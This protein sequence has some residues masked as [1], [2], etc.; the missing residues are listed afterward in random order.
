[1][2]ILIL[3]PSSLGDVIQALPVLRLLKLHYPTSE[4]YWWIETSLSPILKK[5]PDLAGLFVFE[6][7]RWS[8]PLYWNELLGSIRQMRSKKFDLVIDLQGLARSGTFAWLA[9][10]RTLIGVDDSREGASAYYDIRVPRPSSQGH[11]VDW[12]LEVVKRLG[13]PVDRPFTWLPAD[14][15]VKAI[16]DQQRK[17]IGK[18]VVLNPGARWANKRWPTG[19]FAKLAQSL[20]SDFPD[21]N[22]V[23]TGGKSESAL[24]TAISAELPNRC[25]D[26]VGRTT[27]VEMIEWI[28]G[29]ELIVTNDTGP[30]HIAAALGKQVLAVFGPT[31]P[32]RTGPY[33]PG[34]Q[35]LRAELPCAPCMKARCA[36]PNYLECLT[37]VTPE[38]VHTAAH[39][40][41]K[42][43]SR[44]YATAE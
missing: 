14:N 22:F 40:I 43:S 16:V 19:Y 11:A 42:G 18:Y 37:R 2:K 38:M 29:C 26:I 36:N 41:L 13:V 25:V 35:V 8:S 9:N 39:G 3:K 12:Y 10:G 24:A 20:S 30:M 5:D 27:L 31:N 32:A 1:M 21:L 15:Y 28:R 33:G 4:I 44:V 7:K 23:I 6:R 34:N 17:R